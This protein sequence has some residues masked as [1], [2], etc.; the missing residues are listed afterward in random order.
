MRKATA[1]LTPIAHRRILGRTFASTARGIM[2]EPGPIESA[3]RDKLTAQFNPI[4]LT[5]INDSSK[6]RHHAPMRADPASAA[7]GET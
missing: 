5:I 7:S 4:R 6:H 1:V 2:S 3:I